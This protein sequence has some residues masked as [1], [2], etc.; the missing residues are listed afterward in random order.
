MFV[1]AYILYSLNQ[2]KL[3]TEGQTLST[4]S[5]TEKLQNLNKNSH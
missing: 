5:L 1:T 3:K 2:V 4:E